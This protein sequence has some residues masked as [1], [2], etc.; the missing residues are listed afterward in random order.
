MLG[1]R[2]VTIRGTL[3]VV[4]VVTGMIPMLSVT[5]GYQEPATWVTLQLMVV[6]VITIPMQATFASDTD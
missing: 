5:T 1:A 6:E 4:V 2:L 3:I